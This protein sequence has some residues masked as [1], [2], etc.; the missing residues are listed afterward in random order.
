MPFSTGGEDLGEFAPGAH[1]AIAEF[2]P[3]FG[4]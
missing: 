4:L 3:R 1:I 2:V